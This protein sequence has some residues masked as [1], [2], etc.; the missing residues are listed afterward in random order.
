VYFITDERTLL[1]PGRWHVQA[2]YGVGQ[3]HI[4]S[5]INTFM[6]DDNLDTEAS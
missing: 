4:Y 3:T 1:I 6:L 5:S 2:K